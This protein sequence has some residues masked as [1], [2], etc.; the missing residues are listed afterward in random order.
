VRDGMILAHAVVEAARPVTSPLHVHFQWDN[1]KAAEEYRLYQAR[2]LVQVV[3][4]ERAPGDLT[5]SFVSVVV[6]HKVKGQPSEMV[7]AYV[8][9]GKVLDD[10][11]LREQMLQQAIDEVERWSHKYH[12]FPELRELVR[13]IERFS[14]KRQREGEPVAV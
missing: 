14:A 1:D 6:E 5:R 8:D 10:P 2:K 13:A 7:R 9:V 3:I 12:H 4:Y 11:R